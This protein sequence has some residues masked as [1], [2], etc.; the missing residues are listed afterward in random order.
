[1]VGCVIVQGERIIG[2][3]YTS[4]FGG[5][6]AEVN[7]I[8][9]V[10]EKGLLSQAAL[11]VS[12]EPCSHYGK[13]P[14]CVDLILEHRIPEVYIGLRDPH[15][16]VAGRG[17]AKLLAA[18]TKVTVG[19]EEAACREHHRRF[20]CQHQKHRPYVILK[21]AQTQDGFMAPSPGLRKK[22]PEPYWISNGHSRQLVHKWRTEE[23]AI[24]V[25]TA[26]VLADDPR[27]TVRD[28]AGNNPLRVVLDRGLDIPSQ[29]HV[30]DRSVPTLVLTQGKIPPSGGKNIAYATLDFTRPLAAQIVE[31]L[32]RHAVNSVLV[33]G[34]A[35]T[36]QA[37]L[38]ENLWDEARVFTGPRRFFHGL[39]APRPPRPPQYFETVMTDTLT[40]YRND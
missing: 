24:L 21:W 16:K 22:G 1:M 26:T 34:G 5:P 4:P 30:M 6:H 18:G 27:L 13:T 17:I 12:L 23:Q 28:W 38:D 36:L 2:E 20:L 15:E 11:Y 19:I 9:S 31:V 10:R 39:P 8:G 3:G 32:H 33:E 37:F 7:A 35:K 14:P 25:G 40:L 29:R